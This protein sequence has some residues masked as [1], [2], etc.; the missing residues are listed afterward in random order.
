M[1][2]IEVLTLTDKISNR[3]LYRMKVTAIIKDNLISEVRKYARGKN[4]TD[5]LTITLKEWVDLKHIKELNGT[6][7]DRPLEFKKKL[8]P[9]MSES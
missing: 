5:S 7:N 3:I 6:V 1:S 4:L 8:K 9:Q 2:K